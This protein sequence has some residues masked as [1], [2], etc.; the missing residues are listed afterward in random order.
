VIATSETRWVCVASA[1]DEPRAPLDGLPTLIR[2]RGRTPIRHARR[3]GSAC[4]FVDGAPGLPGWLGDARAVLEHL[5]EA[6]DD[7][8]VA[9][10]AEPTARRDD[11]HVRA[12]A[13]SIGTRLA[14]TRAAS[15]VVA[16][17]RLGP[18][19]AL[20]MLEGRAD[21]VASVAALI[22]PVLEYDRRHRTSLLD[23]LEAYLECM[24]SVR[25]TAQRCHAHINSIYYRLNR[26]TELLGVQWDHADRVLDIHLA[27]R[28]HRVLFE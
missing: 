4:V 26:I 5:Q 8:F 24:G 13:L 9:V 2:D 21:V 27:V 28:A 14:S 25:R 3:P 15:T 6:S 19:S 22:G 23:T 20:L 7:V 17:E 18:L 16:A 12:R 10:V 1:S 11:D